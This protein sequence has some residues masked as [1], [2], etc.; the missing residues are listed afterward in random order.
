MQVFFKTLWRVNAVL[1]FLALIAVIVFVVL[2]SKER[3][4]KP[5]LYYFV[6]PP[7]AAAVKPKPTY[8]YVLEKDLLV[9]VDTDRED[10][11]IYRLV[12]W[13]KI[14]GQPVT[15][16]AAATVNLLTVDKKTG[17]AKWLFPGFDRAIV[18][19]E[20]VLTGR[21]YWHEPEA[22][23]DIP[24]DLVVLNVVDAD[25]DGDDALTEDDRHTL[26]VVR[27]GSGTPP[28]KLLTADAVWFT[29]QKNKD[30]QVG[31]RE[32]GV[33]YLA[34]YSLPDFTLTSK[35]RIEGMPR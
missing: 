28:E 8:S 27:F 4:N 21:W 32:K 12:R 30:Y 14:K 11:E 3:I 10:F 26:Y 18:G 22:D 5:L 2:F 6:P 7:P 34:T 1:V 19:Q 17:A 29:M 13:G 15:P 16:E 23:D 25:S 9:G 35:T 24:V 20:T 31:Y 33:G